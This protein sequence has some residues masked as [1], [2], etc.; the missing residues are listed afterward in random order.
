L[1]LHGRILPAHEVTLNF[2]NDMF[3]PEDK[4]FI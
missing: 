2:L 1:A 3:L 4:H